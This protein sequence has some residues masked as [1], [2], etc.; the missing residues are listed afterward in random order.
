MC[1][2]GVADVDLDEDNV[3]DCLEQ[4]CCRDDPLF[5]VRM[6]KGD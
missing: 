3:M 5:Q 4:S 2:C 6:F 1:G